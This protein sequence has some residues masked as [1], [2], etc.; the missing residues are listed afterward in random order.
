MKIT[1]IDDTS[2]EPLELGAFT[3]QTATLCNGELIVLCPD[4]GQRIAALGVLAEY[5]IA[6]EKDDSLPARFTVDAGSTDFS[7][8]FSAE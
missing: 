3:C 1:L 6:A 2:A 4:K 5:D 8:A 7:F